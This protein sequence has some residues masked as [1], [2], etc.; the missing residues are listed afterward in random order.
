MDKKELGL[1]SGPLVHIKVSDPQSSRGPRYKYA[2]QAKELISD[3]LQDM[4]DRDI[5]ERSTAAWLSPIVLVNKPDGSKR[6]CLDY[7]HVNKQL[8]GDI[9]PLPRLGEFVEQAAR[10]QYYITL[11]MCEAF[12]KS[13]WTRKVVTSPSSV[14]GSLS[15]GSNVFHLV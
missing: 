6:M 9:Y 11:D 14:T 4:E 5:I 12:F 3:M 13:F 15:I 10:H 2:D 7:R 8:S 1:I